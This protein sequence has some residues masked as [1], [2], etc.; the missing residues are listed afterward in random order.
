[1]ASLVAAF[2]VSSLVGTRI[3]LAFEDRIS[4]NGHVLFEVFDYDPY[5]WPEYRTRNPRQSTGP[6]CES[7]H[8]IVPNVRSSGPTL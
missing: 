8:L 5:E 4:T 3:D 7:H 2:R 6:P 1:M